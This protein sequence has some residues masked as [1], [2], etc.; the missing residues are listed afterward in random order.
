[1]V[2]FFKLLLFHNFFFFKKEIHWSWG[3][4][5]R[6]QRAGPLKS[7]ISEKC[8]SLS[9]TTSF[10]QCFTHN[11]PV[12]LPLAPCPPAL[13]QTGTSWYG[14]EQWVLSEGEPAWNVT[15]KQENRWVFSQITSLFQL[16]EQPAQMFVPAGKWWDK[17]LFCLISVQAETLTFSFGCLHGIPS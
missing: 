11:K 15:G 16:N 14:A 13:P 4:Y 8:W 9:P 3:S 1:M 12:V 17:H 5:Q 6:E 2:Q 7:F 10:A